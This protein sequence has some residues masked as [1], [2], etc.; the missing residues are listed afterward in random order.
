MHLSKWPLRYS[1][2]G[3]PPPIWSSCQ[4]Q[5]GCSWTRPLT[6]DADRQCSHADGWACGPV[7]ERIEWGRRAVLLLS[8]GC[9][10]GSP[11][12]RQLCRKLHGKISAVLLLWSHGVPRHG[13][14]ENTAFLSRVGITGLAV[15][16]DTSHSTETSPNSTRCTTKEEADS[17]CTGSLVSGNLAVIQHRLWSCHARHCWQP[18]GSEGDRGP[19]GCLYLCWTLTFRPKNHCWWPVQSVCH[20]VLST[21]HLV[22][23]TSKFRN[24]GQVSGLSGGLQLKSAD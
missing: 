18:G 22:D 3:W 5:W 23:V 13:K 8:P 14:T 4:W 17:I 24:V 20:N 2:T 10:P 9:R 11:D 15:L 12:T 6:L 21:R 1:V 7:E 16:L 19:W